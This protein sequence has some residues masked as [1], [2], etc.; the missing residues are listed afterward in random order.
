MLDR[1]LK[2]RRGA[3]SLEPAIKHRHLLGG[4]QHGTFGSPY[5]GCMYGAR[6]A[7]TSVASLGLS[8]AWLPDLREKK[9]LLDGKESLLSMSK[10]SFPPEGCFFPVRSAPQEYDP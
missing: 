4:G 3:T 6:S 7:G 5:D 2:L 1:W 9:S 10:D 8:Y